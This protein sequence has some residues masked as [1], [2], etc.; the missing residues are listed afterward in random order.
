MHLR[1]PWGKAATLWWSI[2]T[3][4]NPLSLLWASPHHRE[5]EGRIHH[6]KAVSK[7]NNA[8]EMRRVVCLSAST[9]YAVAYRRPKFSRIYILYYANVLVP[10]VAF[11]IFQ[12]N[13]TRTN[14]R[15]AFLFGTTVQLFLVCIPLLLVDMGWRDEDVYFG[16]NIWFERGLRWWT[17][18]WVKESVLQKNGSKFF[19]LIILS[20]NLGTSLRQNHKKI[21]GS[22]ALFQRYDFLKFSMGS[23]G[24]FYFMAI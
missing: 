24:D 16:R 4:R 7:F 10:L 20:H 19:S 6:H 12:Q 5:C 1:S 18:T 15:C 17:Q 2:S 21:C 9:E 11:I 14:L 13:E 23:Y 3:T 22:Q 8:A